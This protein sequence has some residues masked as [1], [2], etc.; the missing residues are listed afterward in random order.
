MLSAAR[1]TC[2]E[3][4]SK[5]KVLFQKLVCCDAFINAKTVLCYM[6]VNDEIDT[7]EI[8]NYCLSQK[9]KVAL[10]RVDEGKINFFYIN[11]FKD[12][13]VGFRGIPAPSS[14]CE[15]VSD[16]RDSVC[17]VPALAFDRKNHRIGYGGGFYDRFLKD[18][19]GIKIG[20][21]YSSNF[22]DELP[23]QEHDVP[24]D[25]LIREDL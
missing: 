23:T 4:E 3:R 19:P 12:L 18:Y 11:D 5:D 21:C 16:Y 22:V 17:I 6:S 2:Q 7:K 25:L 14:D 15:I 1:K 24:V 10:P 13:E 8:V 20:L 9:K